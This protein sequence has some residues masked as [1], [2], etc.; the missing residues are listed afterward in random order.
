M[1]ENQISALIEQLEDE[2]IRYERAEEK[3]EALKA[4]LNDH[5]RSMKVSFLPLQLPYHCHN[6]GNEV[7]NRWEVEMARCRSAKLIHIPTQSYEAIF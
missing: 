4:L 1:Y 3:S 6:A 5:E 7:P 2:R